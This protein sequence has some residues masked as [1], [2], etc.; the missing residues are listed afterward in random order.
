MDRENLQKTKF[1]INNYYRSFLFLFL[2]NLCNARC[3]FCYAKPKFSKRSKIAND[4]LDKIKKF[5]KVAHNLNFKEI[6]I[7]GGEPT[8]FQNLSDVLSII[9]SEELNY[10]LLTNGMNLKNHLNSILTNRPTKLS[11]SFHSLD[12]YGSILGIKSK[13]NSVLY[14]I[15]KLLHFR[16]NVA[17]TIL[18]IPENEK[19][20][21]NLIRYFTDMGVKSFKLI[22]PNFK[23]ISMRMY[24]HFEETIKFLMTSRY[25]K[26]IEIKFTDFNQTFCLLKYR[27]FLSLTL[28]DFRLYN[29]CT[30]FDNE[31]SYSI[32]HFDTNYIS[33]ALISIYD[34]FFDIRNHLCKSYISACPISLKTKYTN[35]QVQETGS[36]TIENLA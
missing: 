17:I 22:Y 13:I 5:V 2:P 31:K 10:T 26:S 8:I 36:E 33:S 14:A 15:E 1:I 9:K 18:F 3:Y 11:I 23:N 19:E 28:P 16:I 21:I 24:P 12:N 30:L 29:C 20:I 25:K 34:D 7:T 35:I 32:T 6:R 27:G 4:T